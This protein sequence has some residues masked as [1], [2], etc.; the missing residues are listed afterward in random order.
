MTKVSRIEIR[1]I[2]DPIEVIH[3]YH[4][5]EFELMVDDLMENKKYDPSK[6]IRITVSQE[7]DSEL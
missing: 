2:V 3:G 7:T 5:L 4:H 1:K 6:P